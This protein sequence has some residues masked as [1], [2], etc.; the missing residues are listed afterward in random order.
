MVIGTTS[1]VADE[2][3]SCK[4]QSQHGRRR[5]MLPAGHQTHLVKVLIVEVGYVSDTKYEE[6]LKVE[7]AQ[8]GK[9]LN[10]FSNAGV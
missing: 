2:L 3:G 6:K 10:A 7:M 8:H 5:G 1:Q 9:L 4:Q